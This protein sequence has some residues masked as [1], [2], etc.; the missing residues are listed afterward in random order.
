MTSFRRRD[1]L[2]GAEP[3]W[4]KTSRTSLRNAAPHVGWLNIDPVAIRF[5]IANVETQRASQE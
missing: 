2:A 3:C 5:T 1:V 4:Q